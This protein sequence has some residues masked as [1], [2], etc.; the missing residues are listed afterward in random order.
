[1]T[2]V[3][4]CGGKST[5]MGSDKGLMQ[6]QSITWAELAINKLAELNVP[7]V[8]SVNEQQYQLYSGRFLKSI[9]V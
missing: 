4:L 6:Y 5:R 7:V 8:L 9:I 2:G 3:I 1:M